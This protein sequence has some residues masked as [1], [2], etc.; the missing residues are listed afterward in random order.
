MGRKIKARA[1][2][3]PQLN[4]TSEETKLSKNK[5]APTGA[6][7][8]KS[9]KETVADAAMP[10]VDTDDML[11]ELSKRTAEA[12]R[13]AAVAADDSAA[14][15]EEAAAVT[16]APAKEKVRVKRKE[17]LLKKS[18]DETSPESFISIESATPSGDK[19]NQQGEEK[20]KTHK[21]K[22]RNRKNCGVVYLSHVP[23]GFYEKQMRQFFE[24]FGTVENLRIGRSDKTGRSKGYAFV[25]FKYLEVAKIVAETMNN[26]LM[27]NK[28]LKCEVLPQEKMSRAI[29][30]GKIN[31]RHPPGVK[32]RRDAKKLH[33]SVKSEEAV[34]KCAERR[35]AK[36]DKL[37]QKLAGVGVNYSIDIS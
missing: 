14:V 25:E 34:K 21:K 37:Q 27:F 2:R 7:V 4:K 17:P 23:H 1:P 30:C 22:R 11:R 29:F 15:D 19:E 18:T 6:A 32:K 9:A 10:S 31:P 24:Q 13:Q 5:N 26:Y 12:E 35:T 8:K 16:T 36:L 28:I 3:K 20:K 33:N